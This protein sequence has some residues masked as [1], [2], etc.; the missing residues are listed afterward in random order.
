MK[1]LM[2]TWTIYDARLEEFCNVC[3]GEGL[4]VKNLCEY[5]GRKEEV[6]LFIGRYIL[7]SMKLG[8]INIVKN[9]NKCGKE[10]VR[11]AQYISRMI[12]KFEEELHRIKPDIVNIHGIGE[13]AI[14]CVDVC[15]K[16][17]IPFV[18]TEHLFIGENKMFSGYDRN[19]EW[20]KEL[21]TKPRLKIIAVSNGMKRRILNEYPHILA[22]D[23]KAIVNG[24]DFCAERVENNIKKKIEGKRVLLCVGTI[25]ERKNQMQIL[26]AFQHLPEDLREN[27]LV[28]F[29][30]VD[31]MGGRLQE[32][33][34]E[35][36]L[37]DHFFYEGA[38]SS[39]KMKEYY[40]MA[41][42]LIMP[43]FAE[44][45]SI[46]ALEAISYG[47]PIIM[48]SD[49]ECADDLRDAK[50]T[51]LANDRTDLSL[52]RTIQQWY[53]TMWDK[54]YILNY[55]KRFTME[56]MAEEYIAYYESVINNTFLKC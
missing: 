55:S 8:N 16:R 17:K 10:L 27:L 51:I 5:I 44:G 18:Y 41:D 26:R 46:A 21:Y 32:R 11:D 33:V 23:V 37:Q 29:C 9:G 15:Q 31:R 45:L 22:E 42:G 20:E 13:M 43:S 39:D 28:Y 56:H 35:Q 4:V 25:I 6:Y 47:L 3:G 2:V 1:I 34:A 50:V 36:G 38:V 52:A 49:L 19:V 24:T 14:G 7:P 48:F 40:S 30:G 54:T 12:E 53:E